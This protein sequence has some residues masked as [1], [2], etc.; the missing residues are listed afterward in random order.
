LR[1][2]L[3]FGHIE[4]IEHALQKINKLTSP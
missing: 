4:N 1:L 2:V 3:N